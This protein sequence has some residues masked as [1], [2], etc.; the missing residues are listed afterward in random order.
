MAVEPERDVVR[1]P[2]PTELGQRLGVEDEQERGAAATVE[3]DRQQD[4]LVLASIG[5]RRGNED[6]LPRVCARLEPGR[7]LA[8]L[9]VELDQ[10]VDE[11]R[12]IAVAVGADPVEE[13]V[14]AAIPLPVVDLR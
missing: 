6:R 3:D 8:A 5:L 4:A 11:V 7:L 2:R 10:L 9:D 13:T 14:G 1:D 12:R